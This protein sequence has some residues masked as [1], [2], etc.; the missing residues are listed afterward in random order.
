MIVVVVIIGIVSM[1]FWG[2]VLGTPIEEN[3][4]EKMD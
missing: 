4:Y 1:A 3:E 2:H